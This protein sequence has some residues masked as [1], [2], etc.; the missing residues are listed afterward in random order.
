VCATP[1]PAQDIVV[2]TAAPPSALVPSGAAQPAACRFAKLGDALTYAR[3]VWLPAHAPT[4]TAVTVRA[5]GS[6]MPGNPVIFDAESFPLVVARGVTLATSATPSEAANWIV[7]AAATGSNL[8]ELHDGAIIDGFTVRSVSATGDGIVVACLGATPARLRNVVVDGGAALAR[9][10]VVGDG[11]CGLEATQLNVT[12][13]TKSG[14]HVDTGS[15]AIGITVTDGSLKSNGESG[16]E[17]VSGL[18]S[19]SGSAARFDIS[20][21]ARH[22][23]RA[24]TNQVTPRPISLSLAL[25]DVHNNG[26]VGVLVRDLTATSAASVTSTYIRKNSATPAFSLYGT[27]RI[28][29]GLLLW[30]RLPMT[31]DPT[32]VPAFAFKAN[33][34]CSNAGDAIG[35]FSDDP[36]PL[37]GDPCPPVG[38][39]NNAFAF[40]A[41]SSYYVF[42]TTTT[43]TLVPARNNYWAP[44]PPT[45]L[46]VNAD[47]VPSCGTPPAIP[48][49]CN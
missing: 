39:N 45:G 21:N 2:D 3:D 7:S 44:N 34:V 31:Q 25:A 35:I 47:Y 19:I 10:V 15:T 26:Q 9:G 5:I 36:W 46:V 48:T 37:S 49:E 42:S 32:P 22:G 17:V 12:N 20:S 33:T 40:P 30:G 41:L 24:V 28:A 1:S 11:P 13:A 14:L 29:G 8:V 4:S 6:S 38:S 27:G 18:L 43:S 23:V 16:A